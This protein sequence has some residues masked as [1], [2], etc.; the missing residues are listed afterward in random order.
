MPLDPAIPVWPRT[1][2]PTTIGHGLTRPALFGPQPLSGRPQSVLSDMGAW[3]VSFGGL[4]IQDAYGDRVRRFRALLFGTLA[5]GLPVYL[6]FYDWRRNARVRTGLPAF[7]PG[8]VHDDY[9]R[10]TDG[11]TYGDVTQDVTVAAVA[12]ARSSTLVVA[13]ATTAIPAMG[14]FIGVSDRVYM[15]TGAVAS[16]TVAGQWTLAIAPPLRAA[17]AIGDLVEVA[18]PVAPMKLDPRGVETL[19]S[20]DLSIIGR[21]SLDFYETNW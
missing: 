10:F 3:R 16:P 18:D 14:E 9:T 17:V 4:W 8:V 13:V 5:K 12:A 15:V 19:V 11:T 6:P 21:V 1:L 2:A 20:L 7:P